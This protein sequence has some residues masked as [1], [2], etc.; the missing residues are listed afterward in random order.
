MAKESLTPEQLKEAKQL[1]KTIRSLSEI[2]EDLKQY[3]LDDIYILENWDATNPKAVWFEKTHMGFPVKYRV[4]FIS[5]TGIPY[6]RK[7]TAAGN[8]TGEALVPPEATAIHALRRQHSTML[9]ITAM[10]NALFSQRFAPD[11]EQLD[12][13]LLQQEFDPM[14]QHAEKSK[15]FNDI[16]RHN[17]NVQVPTDYNNYQKI[18]DFFKTR[19]AGD[20]FWTSPDK[21]FVVQSVIKQG[22]QW[23]ITTTDMNQATATFNISSFLHKRLYKEQPRSF[24]KESK[25]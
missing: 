6:L 20:K 12:A 9:N 18:A 21:Q 15:L 8:P 14:A 7:L 17:K 2:R 19:K 24:A 10:N 16:N 3:K 4:V 1:D 11:P 5:D 23:I 22:K 13:I 25:V